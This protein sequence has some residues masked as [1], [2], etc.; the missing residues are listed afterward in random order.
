MPYADPDKRKAQQKE[1][2]RRWYERNRKKHQAQVAKNK[3]ERRQKWLDFKAT[4][5]CTHCGAS[6]PA[7]LDFHHVIR[8]ETYQSVH[9]LAGEGRF[10]AAME[11][12]KKCIP[13]CAN[14][15]RL[16]HFAEVSEQ[17][18]ARRRKRKKRKAAHKPGP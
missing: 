14:C 11:E 15:H 8:D 13:L 18:E 4:L 3:R 5:A 7:I 16:L 12:T 10:S 6:H 17:K 9:R 2:S 1:Y